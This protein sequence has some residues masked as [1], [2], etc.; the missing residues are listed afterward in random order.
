MSKTVFKYDNNYIT[1]GINNG[2]LR[3]IKPNTTLMANYYINRGIRLYNQLLADIKLIIYNI[4]FKITIEKLFIQSFPC[5][6]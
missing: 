3:L 5:D 4:K 6:V 2:N 1:R